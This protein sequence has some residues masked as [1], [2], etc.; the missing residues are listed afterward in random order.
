MQFHYM[1]ALSP[2]CLH[3]TIVLPESLK[4][5]KRNSGIVNVIDVTVGQLTV[6]HMAQCF[7][8][9]KWLPWPGQHSKGLI[10]SVPHGHIPF[11]SDG[12]AST[13]VIKILFKSGFHDVLIRHIC[14]CPFWRVGPT[15]PGPWA[16]FPVMA[17]ALFR[18]QVSASGI[19]SKDYI[20]HWAQ[21]WLPQIPLGLTH[22]L[23]LISEAES[24]RF[25][26]RRKKKRKHIQDWLA[27]Q[28]GGMGTWSNVQVFFC[29][30]MLFV[31][32]MCWCFFVFCFLLLKVMA[33]STLFS[34]KGN[35]Y[36]QSA[37]M[38]K[39]YI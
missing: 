25:R 2:V 20:S 36:D 9:L 6:D 34:Q 11:S 22:G 28:C 32:K 3:V 15:R 4:V 39:S 12:R 19:A 35:S 33:K 13:K 24:V 27:W 30:V 10:E 8:M 1:S 17:G 18:S 23:A 5:Y 14:W 31:T 29:L 37:D 26:R 38:D 7:E 16:I 21:A